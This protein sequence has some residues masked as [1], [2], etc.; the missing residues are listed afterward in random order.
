MNSKIPYQVNLK[1]CS[2]CPGYASY[3]CY[4]C[5]DLCIQCKL[6]HV[7]NLDTKHHNVVLHREK[8]NHFQIKSPCADHQNQ[9]YEHY[10]DL[11]G[12]PICA[13]C[14]EHDMHKKIYLEKAYKKKRQ[15]YEDSI[16]NIRSETLYNAQVIH[17]WLR[18]DVQNDISCCRDKVCHCLIRISTKAKSL[19][20]LL[21]SLHEKVI[22]IYK[23]FLMK[24]LQK[25][26]IQIARYINKLQNVESKC[27]HSVYKPVHVFALMKNP[28]LF[29]IQDTPKMTQSIMLSISKDIKMNELINL[30]S[31]IQFIRRGK[32]EATNERLLKLMPSPVLQKSVSLKGVEGCDH[33]SCITSDLIWVSDYQKNLILTDT[34]IGDTIY[35]VNDSFDLRYV[36][37]HSVNNCNELIYIDKEFNINKVSHDTKSKTTIIKRT[38]FI[39]RPHCLCCSLYTS[40]VLVGMYCSDAFISKGKVIRYNSAGVLINTIQED[41]TSGTLYSVPIYI[42]E[43]SNKDIVVSD[44]HRLVV[45]NDIGKHRFSYLG[46]P[47]GPR[48]DPRGVCTDALSHILVC[49]GTTVQMI[50]KDGQFL[51]Y[52]LTEPPGIITPWSISYDAINHILLVG[53]GFRNNTV[54]FYRYIFRHEFPAIPSG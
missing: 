49:D 5:G 37:L 28:S 33:I 8:N 18:P 13:Q 23:C 52:L 7:I 2:R 48:I 21:D 34:T 51:K 44:D 20:D 4:S 30:L 17:A 50:D 36:G 22:S 45:T 12:I 24:R 35:A 39:W 41:Q 32:R 46:P 25:Q 42:T 16:V 14:V 3:F 26:T 15:H 40:D 43:N 1:L 6:V 29:R 54:S 38:D 27:A 10:C 19:K 9:M 47:S 31:D 11:C 53:S